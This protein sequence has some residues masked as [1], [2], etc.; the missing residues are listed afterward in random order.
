[1]AVCQNL[2]PLVNPKIAGKWMFIP[3]ELIIIG[4]DPPPDLFIIHQAFEKH[5]D[6]IYFQQG[7]FYLVG[8]LAHFLFFHSVGKNNPNWRTHIFQRGGSTTNQL[9]LLWESD[10]TMYH[11]FINST[12]QASVLA[13]AACRT[14]LH[15]SW[16]VPCLITAD[17][18]QT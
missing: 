9:W 2:V 13:P 1:M 7:S 10:T 14:D 3:L 17:L 16:A 15:W 5:W 18:F 11:W 12:S 8:G 4:F 6:T